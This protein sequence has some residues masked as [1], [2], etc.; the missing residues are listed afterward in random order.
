VI[1]THSL[2]HQQDRDFAIG[3][4]NEIIQSS[5][6]ISLLLFVLFVYLFITRAEYCTSFSTVSFFNVNFVNASLFP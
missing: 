4:A 6:T 5:P 2:L 1:A 3:I